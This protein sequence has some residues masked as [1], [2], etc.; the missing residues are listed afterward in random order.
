M[1][2]LVLAI[3]FLEIL[4]VQYITGA[5]LPLLWAVAEPLISALFVLLFF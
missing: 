5:K 1:K 3:S 4:N 2:I